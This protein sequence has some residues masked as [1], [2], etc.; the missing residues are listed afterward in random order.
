MKKKT[1]EL[2][3]A[4]D[5]SQVFIWQ[6]DYPQGQEV[7]VQQLIEQSHVLEIYNLSL[8]NLTTCIYT[9]KCELTDLLKDG[10]RVSLLRP[11]KR[12]RQVAPREM[13]S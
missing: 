3:Y 12:R 11:L 7:T 9:E 10:D 8:D 5:P 6:N 1:I 2:I 4:G 13:R